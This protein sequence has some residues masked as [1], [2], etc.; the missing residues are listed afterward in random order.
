MNKKCFVFCH[1]FGF[2]A[3]FWVHLKPYFAHEQ[4]VYLDVGY[5]GQDDMTVTVEPEQ[6][7]EETVVA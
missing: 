2:D 3:S 6:V 1:G 4:A 7:I 5:F